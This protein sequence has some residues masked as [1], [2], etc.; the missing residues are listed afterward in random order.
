MHTRD[1]V[2]D[3]DGDGFGDPF[4]STLSCA[5]EDGFVNNSQDCDD[6]NEMANPDAM[7]FRDA[8][9]DGFGD[10]DTALRTC[11]LH[12]DTSRMLMTVMILMPVRTQSDLGMKMQMEMDLEERRK[13]LRVIPQMNPFPT[14]LD[15]NDDDFFIHPDGIEI[16]DGIDNNCNGDVDDEDILLDTF[17]TIPHFVD[18]DEDGYGS[19]TL[20]GYFCP[21]YSMGTLVFWGL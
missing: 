9:T 2:A 5:Q 19:D 17:T 7:W 8:D 16:C 14:T 6:E 21:S 1:L 18:E 20:L 11:L 10:P 12:K 3:S 4:V 13:F 15:C